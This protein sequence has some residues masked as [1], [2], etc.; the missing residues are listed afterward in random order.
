MGYTRGEFTYQAW[1]RGESAIGKDESIGTPR[2]CSS[3][4]L[5][6]LRDSCVPVLCGGGAGGGGG[7]SVDRDKRKMDD[8]R[9]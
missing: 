1:L 3:L 9:R 2:I 8:A 7:E 4:F 6:P 5:R